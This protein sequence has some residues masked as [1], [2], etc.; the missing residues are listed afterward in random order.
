MSQRFTPN[1]ESRYVPSRE[2]DRDRSPPRFDRRG[3]LNYGSGPGARNSD[4]SYRPGDFSA[5][6]RDLPRDAPRG[7]KAA[8]DGGRGGSFAPRGRGYHSRGDPRDSHLSRRDQDRSEW[9]RRENFD[10]RERRLSSPGRNRSRSP[11]GRDARGGPRELDTNRVPRGG[12]PPSAESANSDGTQTSGGYYGRGTFRGR[13]RGNWERGRGREGEDRE[14]YRMRSRSR[15]RTWDQ[16]HR[17]ARTREYEREPS[18]REDDKRSDWA[19]ESDRLRRDPPPRPDS[20]NS[21]GSL[22]NPPQTPHSAGA[23]TQQI[24]ADRYRENFKPTA[25]AEAPGK[26]QSYGDLKA[27]EDVKPHPLSSRTEKGRN[28]SAAQIPSS[29]PQPT[30]VPAFGSIATRGAPSAPTNQQSTSPKDDAPPSGP[31]R[32]SLADP[33]KAA[34]KAPKAELH[35]IQAPSGP[36]AGTPFQR[37]A[38]SVMS[39]GRPFDSQHDS[40]PGTSPQMSRFG[41]TP[42]RPAASPSSAG[43][44]PGRG[45]P[46]WGPAYP[47]PKSHHP[48]PT[49]TGPNNAPSELAS[50]PSHA[51]GAATTHSSG[52]FG[53]PSGRIPTGPK[54]AQPSIR[55]PMAPRA[56]AGKSATWIN[57]NIQQRPS[58]LS[59]TMRRGAGP[60]GDDRAKRL[61][62][63]SV[64]HSPASH[65]KPGPKLS[66]LGDMAT[67]MKAAE[68]EDKM[69]VSTINV[70]DSKAVS[71][72][73][74]EAVEEMDIQAET[75]SD[76]DDNMDL[77]EE[78]FEDAE[79]Q[80]KKDLENINAKRPASPKHHPE[81]LALLEEVDALAKAIEHL[82]EGRPIPPPERDEPQTGMDIGLPS[83]SS[84]PDG[85]K[86]D[87]NDVKFEDASV[88]AELTLEGLPYLQSGMPTPL[89]QISDDFDC[90]DAV[91]TLVFRSL[92]DEAGRELDEENQ[93]RK[94]YANRYQAWRS[95]VQAYEREKREMEEQT[96]AATPLPTIVP[97]PVAALSPAPEGG[98]RNRAFNTQ[99]DLDQAIA[100]SKAEAD[101]KEK[102]K[103]DREL[104]ERQNTSLTDM[105]KEAVIPGMLSRT[106][107][108]DRVFDDT[109]NLV[110]TRLVLDTFGFVPPQDDFN[111]EEQKQF[112]TGYLNTP[113][114][115]GH[116]AFEIPGRDY[117]DCI[118]HYYLTKRDTPYK[119]LFNRKVNK[120]GRK[121]AAARVG[122]RAN[123]LMADLG[124]RA[125]EGA[126][127]G[128]MVPVTDTGRPRRAAAP[129]FA[130]KEKKDAEIAA[131]K[132]PARRGANAA[133][134]AGETTDG[135][136]EKPAQRRGRQAQ[137]KERAKRGTKTALPIVSPSKPELDVAT[138]VV[139]EARM[140]DPAAR[141]LESAQMLAKLNPGNQSQQL[142]V[143]DP[144]ARLEAWRIDAKAAGPVLADL[145]VAHMHQRPPQA[146]PAALPSGVPQAQPPVVV[147]EAPHHM[148]GPP[149][150][151]FPPQAVAPVK[152]EPRNQS[153]T[154]SY[155]SVQEQ[156]DFM[157]FLGHFGTDWQ[158]ISGALVTKTHTMVC[159]LHEFWMLASS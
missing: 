85:G 65:L 100:L 8:Q 41:G 36:K 106:Q 31:T 75:A 14:S 157:T 103:Q 3:S 54:A 55:A 12:G 121:P 35:Q 82:Q 63:K 137:P 78:D 139:K 60:G 24:N 97:E 146:P 69:D 99:L 32:S 34:P 56:Y 116:I 20:R 5:S 50:R 49:S 115:W 158:K 102:E 16:S 23:S 88:S 45:F 124:N 74:A 40:Q 89:S 86:D 84:E 114:K 109:N 70:N 92:A 46:Q 135:S 156:N 152:G 79:Q 126:G 22:N 155:W 17:D 9:S 119:T 25:S 132:T 6:A 143:V 27:R 47:A 95:K 127:D 38:V 44:G 59:P 148:S 81:I 64:E 153:I 18:Q 1:S 107:Q 96:R 142:L 48:D 122:R 90:Q 150:V 136:A 62:A 93:L 71:E 134:A 101:E 144:N 11:I 110:E 154:T 67:K 118:L 125:A 138:K 13:G 140:D 80:F 147:T 129:S 57:P 37:R 141:E 105:T 4:T 52:P 76:D 133:R 21:T 131:A 30:Q 29:P 68:E 98:R 128:E 151:A 43:P 130:E 73:M 61:R 7:P 53:G 120:R 28:V 104:I 112:I 108:A 42:T 66:I 2:R 87:G 123:N 39:P 94:V 33:I 159:R 117:Q 111:E 145:Q 113:K 149:P 77:N 10:A 58:I 72:R 15:E 51:E 19:G 83:P 91:M 26:P